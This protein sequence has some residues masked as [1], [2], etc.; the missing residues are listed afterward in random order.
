MDY[1]SNYQFKKKTFI[2]PNLMKTHHKNI[3]KDKKKLYIIIIG[4]TNKCNS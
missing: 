1:N 4:L 3:I 2:L